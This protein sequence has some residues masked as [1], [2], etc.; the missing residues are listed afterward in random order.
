[1]ARVFVSVVCVGLVG[2]AA[3]AQP[4]DPALV[5][6]V[7][8]ATVTSYIG[9]ALGAELGTAIARWAGWST[10][11]GHLAGI[12][13]GYA[14]YALGATAGSGLGVALSGRL[15]G[16]EGNVVL[17]FV[18]SGAGTAL[19]FGIAATF[20]TEGAFWLSPPL[21][22]LLGTLGYRLNR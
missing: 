4:V 20:N 14:G 16:L 19:G 15:L 3:A 12:V 7:S 17:G 11:G 5:V 6:Q 18:G 22:A 10:I 13:M 8:V 2:W 1:M 21:A 9:G